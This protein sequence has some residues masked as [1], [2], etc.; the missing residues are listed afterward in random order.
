VSSWEKALISLGRL[1][2]PG[3][4]ICPMR[5]FF[6]EI[7]KVFCSL[8]SNRKTTKPRLRSIIRAARPEGKRGL[9]KTNCK[10][11]SAYQCFEKNGWTRGRKPGFLSGASPLRSRLWR[12]L[13]KSTR[14]VVG[15]CLNSTRDPGEGANEV[16]IYRNLLRSIE[17][18]RNLKR[19]LV[20][21]AIL[22]MRTI[23]KLYIF[24]V[25]R[26]RRR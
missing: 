18:Y 16:E 25:R 22:I 17:L 11:G 7:D 24:R 8:E 23:S 15:R 5:E 14:D 2:P 9:R 3:P 26:R 12:P 1:A 13:F 4:V 6:F 20:F 19:M 21:S 10:F